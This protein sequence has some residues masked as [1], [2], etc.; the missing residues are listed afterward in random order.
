VGKSDWKSARIGANSTPSLGARRSNPASAANVTPWP[1]RASRAAKRREWIDV[2][3]GS[4]G[5]HQD[6]GHARRW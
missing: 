1:R 2:S 5:E 4:G 3:G 6:L